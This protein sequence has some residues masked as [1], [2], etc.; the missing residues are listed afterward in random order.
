MPRSVVEKPVILPVERQA[1]RAAM[2][3]V[4]GTPGGGRAR[5]KK[6]GVQARAISIGRRQ[7]HVRLGEGPAHT[8]PVLGLAARSAMMSRAEAK[9]H[10][11]PT[12][13]VERKAAARCLPVGIAGGRVRGYR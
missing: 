6:P 4:G 13:I 3:R 11:F 12:I 8:E 10:S 1:L 7:G 9:G 5:L 2:P